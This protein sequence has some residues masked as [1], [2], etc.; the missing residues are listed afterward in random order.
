MRDRT[1]SPTEVITN[2]GGTVTQTTLENDSIREVITLSNVD[3]IV[4]VCDIHLG[5]EDVHN[6]SEFSDFIRNE[7]PRINPDLLIISGDFLEFWRSSIETVLTKY[8]AEISDVLSLMDS[9]K[10][11]LIP[12]NH[13]Y[14]VLKLEADILIAEGVRFKSG[15][16]MFK[17]IHGQNYD[18]KNSNN[19]TNE[20]LCLTSDETGNAMDKFSDAISGLLFT[21][22]TY[23]RV[24]YGLPGTV[25]PFG[26]IQHLSNPDVLT[27]ESQ[28][29]RLRRIEEAVELDNE[30]YVLFGHTH[31]EYVSEDSANAGSFTGDELT[32]IVVED[33]QV[34]L[35][36]H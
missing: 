6:P 10:I 12:G 18:P 3:K 21:D 5:H 11:A 22:A 17:C 1:Y 35:K 14:R 8:R 7:V 31:S 24:E 27:Q 36:Q 16:Q 15:D 4:Q 23:N 9:T 28:S 19:Y 30:E 2:L 13:D 20:G 32:Y 34:E 25:T 33:G 29:R 26:P